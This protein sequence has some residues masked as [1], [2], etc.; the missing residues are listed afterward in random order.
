MRLLALGPLALMCAC[1]GPPAPD[2]ALCQ[3]VITRLC[4]ARS[5]AGVNERL[6]LGNEDCQPTL[7]ERTGCGAED[8]T[9]SEPSRERVLSCRL[10]LV[11]QSTDP[12]KAPACED[13]AD[14]VE[15]CPDLVGFLG[16]LQP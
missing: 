6:A 3:D 15:D 5:C 9:F 4:L 13:V 12:D 11:R 16:G 8:F 1:S 2:A 10:P 14:V 7:R